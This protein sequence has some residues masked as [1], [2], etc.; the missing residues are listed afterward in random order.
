MVCSLQGSLGSGWE[1]VRSGCGGCPSMEG[2]FQGAGWLG[3]LVWWGWR[4][5]QGH[6]SSRGVERVSWA[7]GGELVYAKIGRPLRLCA[8]K[9][10]GLFELGVPEHWLSYVC[11]SLSTLI[12]PCED[13]CCMENKD[14]THLSGS[15]F[16][17]VDC[18]VFMDNGGRTYSLC[19]SGL[20]NRC[21]LHALPTSHMWIPLDMWL[22]W[23]RRC[24]FNLFNVIQFNCK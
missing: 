19:K 14:H 4:W 13:G 8:E 15:P 7:A 5:W 21:S 6:I 17:T 22:M 10:G 23:L 2:G 12:L 20:F 11:S 1:S 9:W 18:K 16:Y 3:C 24:I